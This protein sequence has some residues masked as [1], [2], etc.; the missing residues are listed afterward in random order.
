MVHEQILNYLKNNGPSLPVEIGKSVNYDSILTNAVLVELENK[1][2]VKHSRRAIGGSLI[3]YAP[4]HENQMRN[5]IQKDL[6]ILELKTLNR[7]KELGKVMISEL[8]PHERAYL[9]NIADFIIIDKKENDY[10]IRHYEHKNQETIKEPETV[11]TLEE[12][13]TVKAP[14]IT[15]INKELKLFDHASNKKEDFYEKARKKIEKIGEIIN[16][17]R[18][19]QDTEYEFQIRTNNE[20]KQEFLIKARN[21]KSISENEL[22]LIYAETLK[23]KKPSIIITTGKLTAKAQKWK[24]ENAGDLIHVITI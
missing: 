21:K 23:K 4:E 1:G 7:I 2:L 11:K 17:K 10:E 15:P 14:E 9:R 13:Q 12:T 24:D 6:N 18:I 22:G 20:L 16:E 5:V 19:K 3:Y 8:T